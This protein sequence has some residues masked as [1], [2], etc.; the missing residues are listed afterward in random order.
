MHFFRKSLTVHFETRLIKKYNSLKLNHL[1]SNLNTYVRKL[2][3]WILSQVLKAKIVTKFLFVCL[4]IIQTL[5]TQF[6]MYDY[7]T[8]CKLTEK[9]FLRLRTFSYFF[10]YFQTYLYL[11]KQWNCLATLHVPNCTTFCPK[12]GCQA[13]PGQG[14]Q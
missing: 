10:L 11:G 7:P 5:Y 3:L 12:V 9:T 2:I 1:N 6:W 13:R 8:F 4:Q 14:M